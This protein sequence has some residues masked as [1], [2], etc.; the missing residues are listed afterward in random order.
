MPSLV[1]SGS[2]D[3]FGNVETT[4]PTLAFVSTDSLSVR[5][6]EPLFDKIMESIPKCSVEDLFHQHEDFLMHAIMDCPACILYPPPDGH[7]H[8]TCSPCPTLEAH[9]TAHEAFIDLLRDKNLSLCN[10]CFISLDQHHEYRDS[11]IVCQYPNIVSPTLF[12]LWKHP[13]TLHLILHI[14]VRMFS[15]DIP[16]ADL[17]IDRFVDVLAV[18]VEKFHM[19]SLVIALCW[20]LDDRDVLAT[21]N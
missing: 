19:L 13:R 20:Y 12:L 10:S 21:F 4:S 6:D 1:T 3:V 2:S 5:L 9:C 16:R 8:P 17:S 14:L 15:L 18:R 7:V 11:G